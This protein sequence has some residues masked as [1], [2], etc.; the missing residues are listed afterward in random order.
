MINTTFCTIKNSLSE[1]FRWAVDQAVDSMQ[2]SYNT[3]ESQEQDPVGTRSYLDDENDP[4][5]ELHDLT[6]I[7]FILAFISSTR[8]ISACEALLRERFNRY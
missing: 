3:Y 8:R 2:P 5:Q 4:I 7:L 6:L 1:V